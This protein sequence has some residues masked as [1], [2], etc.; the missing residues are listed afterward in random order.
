MLLVAKVVKVEK[1]V[2]YVFSSSSS[3]FPIYPRG[4]NE[5]FR[6]VLEEELDPKLPRPAPNMGQALIPLMVMLDI[7]VHQVQMVT[8]AQMGRTD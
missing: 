3:L 4:S 7:E 2:R 8:E 5:N 1:V 6:E